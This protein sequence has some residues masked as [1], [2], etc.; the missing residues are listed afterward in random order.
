MR[1]VILFPVLVLLLSITS[2]ASAQGWNIG[3]TFGDP[4]RSVNFSFQSVRTGYYEEVALGQAATDCYRQL[5]SLVRKFKSEGKEVL[6]VSV[7]IEE[8]EV[9]Y[10]PVTF[11]LIATWKI[12]GLII[13]QDKNKWPW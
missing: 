11:T 1:S 7:E 9:V 13:V 12:E 5:D 3:W 4:G 6:G 2:S 8:G 10:D